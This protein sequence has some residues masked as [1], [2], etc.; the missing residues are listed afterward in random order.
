MIFKKGSMCLCKCKWCKSYYV[1]GAECGAVWCS[2]LQRVAV[3]CIV[4]QYSVLYLL[5]RSFVLL[6][7]NE[8]A[9]IVHCVATHCNTLQHTATQPMMPIGHISSI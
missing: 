2:V 5:F 3:C 7:N 4:L 8:I 9:K 6:Q 1:F